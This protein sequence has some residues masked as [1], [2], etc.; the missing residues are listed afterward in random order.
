MI[1]AT[2][3]VNSIKQRLE[4]LKKW[5]ETRPVDIVMLQELKG[6]EFPSAEIEK[7]GYYSDFVPQK[8]FNGVAI[9]SK[10]PFKVIARKLPGNDEDAQARY[11]EIDCDG[12]R[13][14][15][16]YLPNGNPIGT[17]KFEYKLLWMDRLYKHLKELRE[18][19][20]PFVIGGD[21]NVIPQD[22]DCYNP[23]NW[24]TDALFSKEAKAKFRKL[25]S[26]GLLDAYRIQ[27]PTTK[28]FTFWDYFG[29]SWHADKGIRIDHFL[30]SPEI[31]DK[32]ISCEIDKTPRDWEKPSDHTPVLLEFA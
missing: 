1:I 25:L 17:E 16:I 12:V 32:F 21:F 5:L 4:H 27:N 11:L 6:M 30:I 2:W 10:K 24:V 19:R 31:A 28:A 13:I 8:G 20:I 3:N 15:N 9:L 18:D 14:I 7:I 29:G 23:A 22:I 26:L